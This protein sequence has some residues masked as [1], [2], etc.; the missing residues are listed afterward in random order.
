MIHSRKNNSLIIHIIC[1]LGACLLMVLS[2]WST[3]IS[4]KG[5]V[6]SDHFNDISMPDNAVSVLESSELE[7]YNCTMDGLH[8][9]DVEDDPQLHIRFADGK[10]QSV[11]SIHFRLEQSYPYDQLCVL[12][13]PERSGEYSE[14]FTIQTT[15]RKGN[16]DIYYVLPESV[17]Y[18]IKDFRIDIDDEYVLE[19]IE[20]SDQ[21]IIGAYDWSRHSKV[22][23]AIICFLAWL[24]ILELICFFRDGIRTTFRNLWGNRKEI[25]KWI[26]LLG[27]CAGA[28]ILISHAA[29]RVAG[30]T[31][32]PFWIALGELYAV[33]VGAELMLLLKR[34]KEKSAAA[35]TAQ[36]RWVWA[37]FWTGIVV[38]ALL[39]LFQ[40]HEASRGEDAWISSL[41]FQIPFV[42]ALVQTFAAA[43]LYQ[44][45]ILSRSDSSISYR[46]IYLICI[47]AMGLAYIFVFLPY[48]SPDETA[49]YTS[50]YRI[51][52]FF[53]GKIGLL[54]DR[55]LLMRVEDYAFY[56]SYS[57]VMTP[58]YYMQITENMTIFQKEAGQ[59]ITS[60]PMVT[61]ALFAYVPSGIAIA[62]ARVLHLS[63]ALTFYAGR[64]GNLLFY[65]AALAYVM[66]KLPSAAC[67]IYA[68]SMMPMTLHTVGSYSY[69]AATFGF[70][71]MF[72]INIMSMLFS[73]E[74]VNRRDYALTM[75]FGILMAPSKLVFVPLLFLVLIVPAEQFG[76]DK[77]DGLKKQI[78]IIAAGVFS[79]LLVMILIGLLGENSAILE[80]VKENETVNMLVTSHEEGYTISWI[81][82][83]L[84]T[85]AIMCV[86]T[87]VKMLDHY[88][89]TMIGNNLGW[90]DIGIPVFY[91]MVSFLLVL[92]ASNIRQDGDEQLIGIGRKAWIVFLSV[93]TILLVMLAMTLDFTPRS[94]NFVH[95]VQGR[96]FTPLLIPAIWLFRTQMVAVKEQVRKRIVLVSV[97]VNMWILV[98]VFTHCIVGVPG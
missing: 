78:M 15:L 66:K 43:I 14:K 42:F 63:G 75:L 7:A 1:V 82:H 76:K 94:L 51:S 3:A 31:I 91:V 96:Y 21:K 70:V 54:G 80:M 39:I 50:A 53:L 30:K 37:V 27:V 68:I 5:T 95:G 38:F 97:M 36:D 40:W 61:N 77:K 24:F 33:T 62:L 45:Y 71:A 92:V 69:D 6:P 18:K 48:I 60:E 88:F 84:G 26:L 35:K 83:N 52:D 19:E 67:A 9:Y 13:Y 86:R 59:I 58:Q 65:I 90:L 11:R 16:R 34:P 46:S 79:A 2:L 22:K 8:I 25:G 17:N 85:Y 44:K 64:I 72:V 73:K 23:P 28:G 20:I 12:Y 10:P 41:R 49:H 74:Q 56:G 81:L 32:S 93:G 89:L 87:M 98:Y 29:V 4:M 57:K 47:F 55:R